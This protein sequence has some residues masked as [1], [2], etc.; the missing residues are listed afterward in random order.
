MC[1]TAASRLKSTIGDSFTIFPGTAAYSESVNAKTDTD[2]TST[3]L[4]ARLAFALTCK[5]ASQDPRV[6]T[7]SSVH[8]P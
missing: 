2:A 7:C 8:A 5:T 3:T 1:G 4:L 6:A